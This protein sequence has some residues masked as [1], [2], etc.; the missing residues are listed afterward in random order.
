MQSAARIQVRKPQKKSPGKEHRKEKLVKRPQKK[1]SKTTRKGCRKKKSDNKRN[2]KYDG[3]A[4]QLEDKV[5]KTAACFFGEQLAGFLGEEVLEYM[6]PTE[7][8]HLEAR[9]MYEDFNYI[10][11]NGEWCHL[12]FESTPIT[13][14]DLRRFREYEATASR[15]YQVPVITYVICSAAVKKIKKELRQ[16]INTYRIKVIY[17]KGESAD[18]VFRQI[19]KKEIITKE[20]MLPVLWSP[21][22]SGTLSIRERVKKGMEAIRRLIDIDEEE[23]VRMQSILYALAVK[24]PDREELEEVKEDLFMTVLGKMLMEEGISRG[25]SQGISQGIVTILQEFGFS[26]EDTCRKIMEKCHLSRE[27]AGE[28]VEK[29]WADGECGSE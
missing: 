11:K 21:L 10:K 3:T 29:Y 14:K 26:K 28:E 13:T 4:S 16:G 18:E 23:K 6:A 8:I 22:M 20:D 9:Q 25:I 12:E 19:E 17:L 7:L 2:E 1:N 27:E 24:L 15:V 5:M